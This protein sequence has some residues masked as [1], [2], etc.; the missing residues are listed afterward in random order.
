MKPRHIAMGTALLAAACLAVWGNQDKPPTVVEGTRG[1]IAS[2]PR[3][4]VGPRPLTPETLPS[5]SEIVLEL[6]PREQLIGHMERDESRSL[7][8]AHSWA[9]SAQ[10]DGAPAEPAAPTAPA[11]PFTYLGKEQSG[12][13]W[14][15]FLANGDTTLVVGEKD[16]IDGQYK[17]LS[18]TPPTMTFE[19]LPLHERQ[20][21]QI[22]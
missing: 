12:Q 22:E 1:G 14:H 10:S 6:A 21:L 13:T 11:L 5:S 7:F 16:S 19:Y 4:A 17:V 18:I 15:V 8:A 2:G 20:T 3:A 9:P